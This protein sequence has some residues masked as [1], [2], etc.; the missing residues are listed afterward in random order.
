MRSISKG[1]AAVFLGL[2]LL[3]PDA[4]RAADTAARKAGEVVVTTSSLKL[5]DGREAP[6]EIGT[7]FVPENRKAKG[8][9]LIGIG[10]ARL[11]AETPTGA[12]PIF[13]LPGG[14]GDSYLG[15]FT[16]GAGRDQRARA[17]L[18]AYRAAADVIVIDQRGFSTRGD[19]LT[20]S[21]PPADRPL[22]LPAVDAMEDAAFI[23]AAKAAIAAHPDKDL[24]GYTVV[25]CAEDV[26]TLRRALGYN[27]ITLLGQSFGS[28]WSFAVMRLHPEIVA[29]ALLSGVEPLNNGYDMPSHVVA[30]LQRIAWEAEQD[31]GLKPYLPPGGLM[32]AADAVRERLARAPVS[33][34]LRGGTSGPERTVVVGLGDFQQSLVRPADA[35]PAFV[36]SLYY[37]HYEEWA[38]SIAAE[39]TFGTIRTALIGALIDTSLGVTAERE[40]QLR[41]DPA[42][43]LL[44]TW[45]FGSYIASAA[46]WPT[47]DIGDA[48]RKPT[49]SDIPV[50][51]VHGDWDTSTPVENVLATLPYFPNGR[52]VVV[53]R[54][55]HSARAALL[56][57][58]PAAMALALDFLRT[59]DMS[60]APPGAELPAPKFKI[61][62]FPPPTARQPS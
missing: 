50:L 57:Q 13:V 53:H 46:T 4:G 21:Y 55:P 44:G 16:E 42:V 61:P 1:A 43:G 9:R 17:Q 34:V 25:E 35:W 41:T 3:L 12:P 38:R 19:V 20:L 59:G 56:E 33:V 49:P 45:N 11:R 26:N 36:L 28:Q 22:D 31:P 27:K 51:F 40:H 15:A 8:S 37:G 58:Q 2:S 5:P 7:L 48:L 23:Q 29:R 54:G 14:P 39:R 30:A 60:R 32:G 6:Y 62:S 10:F 24:S 52:L 47:P 18:L